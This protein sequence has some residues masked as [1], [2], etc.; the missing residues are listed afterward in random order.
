M[1]NKT[2]ITKDIALASLD[3]LGIDEFGL[4]QADRHILETII[5]KF[6]GGPVGLQT[7]AAT[8]FEEEDN[9]LEIYEPYL[10]KLGFL[11]RTPRGRMA[12]EQAYQYLKK[13][14]KLF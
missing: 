4:E 8:I 5:N 6:N 14:P 3:A 9:L 12:S 11:K 7:L 1:Q 13:K 2:T 10:L